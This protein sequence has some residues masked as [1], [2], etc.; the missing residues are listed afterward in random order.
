M[1]PVGL[2][3]GTFTG[4]GDGIE[5]GPFTARIEIVELPGGSVAADYVALAA[6]GVVLH[7]EHTLVS[8]GPDGLHRLH[9]AHSESPF[10]TTMVETAARSGVFVEPAPS[11]P[12]ELSIRIERPAPGRLRWAWWWAPAGERLVERSRADLTLVGS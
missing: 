8:A 7:R 9:V 2:V 5:S 11:G 4:T 6:D 1:T 12:F 3:P 10:V